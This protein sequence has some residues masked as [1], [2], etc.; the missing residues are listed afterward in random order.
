MKF[1]VPA[2]CTQLANIAVPSKGGGE[3]AVRGRKIPPFPLPRKNLWNIFCA[4]TQTNFILVYLESMSVVKLASY[5]WRLILLVTALPRNHPLAC[6]W[7]FFMCSLTIN[8]FCR[9]WLPSK[10]CQWLSMQPTTLWVAL[11]WIDLVCVHNM[12]SCHVAA[13]QIEKYLPRDAI[14]V[15]EGSATMDI[16]RTV[17]QS[18]YPRKRYIFT[19]GTP[20]IINTLK[21]MWWVF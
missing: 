17:F 21:W 20:V 10:P 9:N 6:L 5:C 1:R 8:L 15:N 11:L 3:T 16:G 2:V 13:R 14:L 12:W 19:G 7:I 18:H 4:Y